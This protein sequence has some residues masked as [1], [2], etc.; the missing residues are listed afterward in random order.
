MKRFIDDYQNESFDII[1]I[2]GGITWRG[3]CL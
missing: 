3:G 2:G 1:V